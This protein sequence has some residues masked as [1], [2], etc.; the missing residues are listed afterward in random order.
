MLWITPMDHSVS[1]LYP[2]AYGSLRIASLNKKTRLSQDVEFGTKL[3]NY[4]EGTGALQKWDQL[5][6]LSSLGTSFN[7]QLKRPFTEAEPRSSNPSPVPPGGAGRSPWARGLRSPRATGAPQTSR[8]RWTSCSKEMS[9]LPAAKRT[10]RLKP[11]P[12]WWCWKVGIMLP[13]E[14]FAFGRTFLA[15]R[16]WVTT[17]PPSDCLQTR[18]CVRVCAVCVCVSVCD[19]VCWPFLG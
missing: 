1:L 3:A 14:R 19:C 8:G 6:P 10:K 17:A 7:V 16:C 18:V 9:R 5:F 13:P 4:V 11:P 12:R 2:V 15:A